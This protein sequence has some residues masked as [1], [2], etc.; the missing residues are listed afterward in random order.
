MTRD[1][2]DINTALKPFSVNK[3]SNDESE[4]SY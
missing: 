1:R 4:Q 3:I 2:I